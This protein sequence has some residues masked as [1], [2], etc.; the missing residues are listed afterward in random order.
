MLLTN[1]MPRWKGILA[2]SMVVILLAT[3][4]LGARP[5]AAAGSIELY[6]PYLSLSAPP[7]DTL[8]YEIEVINHGTST[9]NV[10]LNFDDKGNG[11]KYELTSGGRAVNKLA[12]KG[13]E[14]QP[15]LL[16]LIVP[17][18]VDK[19]TYSFQMSAGDAVLPLSVQVSEQGT[20]RTE[21]LTDQPNM[22]GHSD[23]TFSYSVT[24]RNRTANE[25]MYALQAQVDPGWDVSFTDGGTSV[26]SVQ[27][28]PSG[29][30]TINISVKPPEM[31]KAGTYKIP[32]TASNNST[33][34]KLELEAAVTGTYDLSLSTPN[35]LLSTDVTAG[36][37][38]HIDL[39][40]QN[41][42]STDL[43]NVN[44]SA[45]SPSGWEVTFEPKTISTIAAGAVTHVQATIKADKKALSGDY[46]VNI[47]ASAPEKS[48]DAQFRV[49]V[50]SSMLWGWIGI[51]IIVVVA[52]GI[53]F[54]Y[55]KYGRR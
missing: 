15:V 33:S 17:L 40:V 53:Y 32:I 45:D 42:G 21:L 50:K 11:W 47:T 2:L 3:S 37:Q 46:V 44:L 31:V 52:G 38:R 29:E 20:F 39:V 16:Q 23:S 6:T 18:Q 30:K 4:V 54:L 9:T 14:S 22:Q 34:A 25:Q 13:G 48:A 7:G 10:N 12:V 1:R 35:N 55:R 19:G 28:D 43:K 49:E 24:L 8:N 5:A 51:L 41:T 26:T 27:V 36:S